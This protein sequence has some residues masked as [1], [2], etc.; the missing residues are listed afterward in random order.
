MKAWKLLILKEALKILNK[1]QK[2]ADGDRRY[3]AFCIM[4]VPSYMYSVENRKS[5]PK[6]I[7]YKVLTICG[8]V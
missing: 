3:T 4:L 1:K 8:E 6:F 2:E 5:I 7:G